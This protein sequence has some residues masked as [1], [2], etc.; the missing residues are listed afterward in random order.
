MGLRAGVIRDGSTCCNSL[1]DRP[2]ILVI[3][4]VTVVAFVQTAAALANI[5]GWSCNRC[6]PHRSH[7]LCRWMGS[8]LP[9]KVPASFRT[10]F[11]WGHIGIVGFEDSR[12]SQTLC[13]SVPASF[14]LYL[15]RHIGVNWL[16][17]IFNDGSPFAYATF[18]LGGTAASL[19]APQS[20][21]L[22]GGHSHRFRRKTKKGRS[23]I[24]DQNSSS[25][26]HR[27][28]N[29]LEAPI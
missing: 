21:C 18:S 7:S 4:V 5:K 15:P 19:A 23:P 12:A 9:T 11:L 27:R 10:P 22:S 17:A 14:V 1:T 26:S 20:P 28:G 24:L 25:S 16:V 3:A 13:G 29:S 6:R 8:Q 2:T